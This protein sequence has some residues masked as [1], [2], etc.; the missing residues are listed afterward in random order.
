MESLRQFP[1][2]KAQRS[3]YFRDGEDKT[4][5][6]LTQAK[7]IH[8]TAFNLMK[9]L[10]IIGMIPIAIEKEKIKWRDTGILTRA[11]ITLNQEPW[12]EEGE[13]HMLQLDYYNNPECGTKL[14]TVLNRYMGDSKDLEVQCE[15][16]TCAEACIYL[17]L[18]IELFPTE[19]R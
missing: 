12:C 17:D 10:M 11:V 1:L 4:I 14:S 8:E 15:W 13:E 3:A 5:T 6:L 18:S 7:E 16:N 19:Q 9:D 2:L